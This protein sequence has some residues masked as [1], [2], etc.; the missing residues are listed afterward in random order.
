MEAGHASLAGPDQDCGLQGESA[1]GLP[2]TRGGEKDPGAWMSEEVKKT[3]APGS[4]GSR[5]M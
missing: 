3:G 5:A 4:S 2:E 1:L